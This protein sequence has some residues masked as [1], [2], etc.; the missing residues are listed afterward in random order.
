M[1]DGAERV[2][3]GAYRAA[4]LMLAPIIFIV[5]LILI[6]VL[7][8][9]FVEL[10]SGVGGSATIQNIM[11]WFVHLLALGMFVALVVF[12]YFFVKYRGWGLFE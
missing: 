3:Q 4:A 12:C 2:V 7:H 8:E 6:P 10:V 9:V 11:V 1:V 5:G